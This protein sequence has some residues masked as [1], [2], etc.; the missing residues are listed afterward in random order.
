MFCFRW[1]RQIPD[2]KHKCGHPRRHQFADIRQTDRLYT[3]L[4]HGV[5]QI[6]KYQP[7]QT[8]RGR[9]APCGMSFAPN[10][11]NAKPIP[12]KNSPIAYFPASEG[13]NLLSHH[14]EKIGASA[15]INSEFKIKTRSP[16]F[17]VRCLFPNHFCFNAFLDSAS[18][19]SS[20]N[21]KLFPFVQIYDMH[22]L[23]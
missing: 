5:E 14:F 10:A 16:V 12:K 3:E 20:I 13:L 8:D 15:M 6:G 11:R 19:A 9:F 21:L 18:F 23:L 1:Q 2:T 7:D 22:R 17:R 4:A